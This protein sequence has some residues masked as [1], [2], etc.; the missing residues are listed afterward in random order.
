[1][2]NKLNDFA[3]E[4]IVSIKN[5]I[6]CIKQKVNHIK[7]QT[8]GKYSL[9]VASCIGILSIGAVSISSARPNSYAITIEESI[10]AIVKEE[11]E[12]KSVYEEAVLELKQVEGKDIAVLQ[13][14]V[15]TSVHSKAE[16]IL[17]KEEAVEK[18]KDVLSYQVEAYILM[19]NGEEMGVVESE[20]AIFNLLKQMTMAQLPEGSQVELIKKQVSEETDAHGKNLKMSRVQVDTF[21]IP[22]GKEE[23]STILRSILDVDFQQEV[24]IQNT[25]IDKEVLIEAEVILEKLQGDQEDLIQYELVAGDN[26][27]DIAIDNGTTMDHLLKINPQ[28]TDEKRMQIGEVINLQ[29]PTPLLSIATT[30]RAVYKEVV[31][32]DIEYV[33]FSDLY[34]GDTKTYQE[35]ADGLNEVTVDLHKVNGIEEGRTLI[36]REELELPKT[37]VIAYGTKKRP[38]STTTTTARASVTPSSGTFMH[39]L[40]GKGRVSSQYGRRWGTFHYGIDLAASAGTPIYAAAAGKVIYSGYNSGGYGNLIIIE[41]SN[42]FQTYYAHC[43]KLY[44]QVGQNVVKG[45]NIATV[46]STG[47]STGNHLHFEIRSGGSPINPYSYIY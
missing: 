2:I 14:I 11:E 21:T 8:K 1:M 17:T 46:G 5:K 38:V 32:A 6:D 10:I 3:K 41:H 12:A 15:T 9:Y 43:Q 4:Q 24:Y 47:N 36:N 20:E 42:G 31:P 22:E 25:Y 34:E 18:V 23:G 29:I 28:I 33:A 44:A 13:D 40:N 16:E 35:G 19:I 45:Q 7:P 37:K 39:P 27:W 30:E 26:I